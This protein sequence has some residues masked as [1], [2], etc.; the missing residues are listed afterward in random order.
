MTHASAKASANP[1]KPTSL[2]LCVLLAALS[3][4]CKDKMC[5]AGEPPEGWKDHRDL[6]PANAVVCDLAKMGPDAPKPYPNVVH[7]Y[8]QDKSPHEAW[9]QTVTDLEKKGWERTSQSK[10]TGSADNPPLLGFMDKAGNGLKVTINKTN[11]GTHG[12]FALNLKK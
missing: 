11:N 10:D 3:A 7:V 4:S 2:A 5:P 8:F 12:Y 1:M 6:L 9:M